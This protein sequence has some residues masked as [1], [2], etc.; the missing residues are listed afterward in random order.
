MTDQIT[1]KEALKLVEFRKDF[2]GKW[3]VNLVK[4][5]CD[6]VRGSCHFV[7]G[8]CRIIQGDCQIVK[9]DCNLVAGNCQS[10]KGTVYQT[11]NGRKWQYIETPKEA[12]RRLVKAGASKD[13]ILA[14]IDQLQEDN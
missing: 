3:Y 9:G 14:A 4:G 7:E 12:L 8:N 11:I 2:H 1:L 6:W 10:V 13:E 5:D